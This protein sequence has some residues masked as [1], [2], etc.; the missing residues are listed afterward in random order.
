M[1]LVHAGAAGQPLER[2]AATPGAIRSA[3]PIAAQF[4]SRVDL[5]Q[6]TAT[7]L[8]G[9]RFVR[10]LPREAFRVFEDDVSRPVVHFA[11]TDVPMELFVAVDVSSSMRKVIG[12]V[13]ENAAHFLAA[14]PAGHQVTLVSFN[15]EW[16]VLTEPP[17]PLE[18]QLEAIAPLAPF[19]R[20]SLYDV[21]LHSF[22]S[23][24]QQ[25]GRR[26][27]VLFTD[28]EDTASQASSETVERRAETSDAVVYVVG[29]GQALKSPDLKELC[30]RLA[31]KS[32]GRAFFPHEMDQLREAFDTI[33]DEMSSQ[34]LIVY[35]PRSKAPDGKWHRIRV[36]AA[37][38]RYEVRAR[39]GYRYEGSDSR[40]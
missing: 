40:Q 2:D 29:H 18:A 27:V 37:D 33:V 4:S 39:Q 3:A 22:D 13:K 38:L 34:Y 35:E 7:V 21:M 5:V 32:G 8:D 31:S 1:L 11:A 26:A 28:G 19:G 15:D 36:E 10:G 24:G 12:Q 23:L 14:L 6:V 17:M 30:E 16:H 9:R 20:T 25:V